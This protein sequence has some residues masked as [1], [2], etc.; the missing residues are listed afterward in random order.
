MRALRACLSNEDNKVMFASV[1]KLE[2]LGLDTRHKR[3]HTYHTHTHAHTRTHTHTHAHTAALL[4]HSSSVDADL[5]LGAVGKVAS[6]YNNKN[7]EKYR[8]ILLLQYPTISSH[9]VYLVPMIVPK[10]PAKIVKMCVSTSSHSIQDLRVRV[11][12]RADFFYY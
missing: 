11:C 1:S 9:V 2:F 12:K 3:V 6:K 4:R 10:M 8:L 7:T 5:Q